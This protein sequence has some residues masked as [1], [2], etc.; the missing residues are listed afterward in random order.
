MQYLGQVAKL[1]EAM[2]ELRYIRSFKL[3]WQNQFINQ[4][5]LNADTSVLQNCIRKHSKFYWAG[6][7]SIKSNYKLSH[8]QRNKSR[9]IPQFFSTRFYYR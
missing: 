5:E 1:N 8:K 2:I 9:Q 7:H 6:N 4:S 3:T